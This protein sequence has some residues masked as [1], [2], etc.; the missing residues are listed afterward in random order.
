MRSLLVALLL[1]GSIS[2]AQPARR[3]GNPPPPP[4]PPPPTQQAEQPP[5]PPPVSP[6]EMTSDQP[7]INAP[8]EIRHGLHFEAF[9]DAEV[10]IVN[11]E[12]YPTR[13]FT[14]NDAAIYLSKDFGRGLSAMVD[15]PFASVPM[16]VNGGTPSST[17]IA[18][19]Q[20]KAQAYAQWM[21][22]NFTAKL[23]QYDTMFGYEKNDSRDRFFANAGLVK[24]LIV[25]DTHVG[26]LGG[27]LAGPLSIR[28]QIA[29]PSDIATMAQQ[30]PEVGVQVR[31]DGPVFGQVGASYGD[32]KSNGLSNVLIDAAV[33]L[34]LDRLTGAVYFDDRKYAGVD[35]HADGFGVQGAYALQPD[36]GVGARLEYVTDPNTAVILPGTVK[37]EFALAVGPSWKWLP[38]LT[39]R[40]DLD[41]GTISP[42]NGDSTTIF[43]AQGSV[44]AS[45]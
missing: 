15:L 31:Y 43:G 4:P 32:Q 36:L 39:L 14:L 12:W 28:A 38:D 5:P 6:Q 25:P 24:S 19:G 22:T 21:G 45:F 13:G 42:Y 33:G 10:G 41:V 3:R 9:L 37:N 26:L 2:Q 18:F 16:A 30:N 35:K 20:A 17:S 7:L 34:R 1:I 40:G 8:T 27:Y 11:K 44:V 23:G 29:D